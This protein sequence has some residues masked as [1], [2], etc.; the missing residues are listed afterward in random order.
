MNLL[1]PLFRSPTVEAELSEVATL[2][3]MLDFESALARAESRAGIFPSSAAASISAACRAEKF[4]GVT[5]AESAASAGNLAIPLIKQLTNLVAQT[6]SDAARYVHF[7]A[8]SQDAIDTGRILQLRR[9]LAL[10]STDLDQLSD[11]LAQ[12]A[13]KHRSTLITARTWMQHALPT[14]FGAKVAGW[15]DAL[16]RDRIRIRETQSR[17]VVLQ[18]GGAVGTLAALG[19]KGRE[20]AKNLSAE[21]N[22]P[23]THLPW[24]SNRDRMAEMATTLGLCTGTLGKIARDISLHS[25]TE[26]AEL[27]EPAAPGRGGSSTMPHKRN[28]I[29][30]AIVLSAALRVPALVATMLSAMPQEYERGLGGWHAEWE[31]LPEIV[32]LAAGAL[33]HLAAIAAHLEVDTARMR[34]NLGLTHGLIY[35]EAV[36]IA[37]SEKTGRPSAHALLE[38]A[39]TRARAQQKDLREILSNDEKISPHLSAQDLD[40]LFDPNSYLGSAESFVDEVL[41]AHVSNRA[42]ISA[43]RS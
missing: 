21:L 34:Q 2:Q 27:F 33:H 26:I 37:L 23:L 6:D 16:D 5:L 43:G 12:L 39:C 35:A 1:A 42:T 15:L 13:K 41:T 14:T 4:D 8:T 20:V 17:C 11:S 19:A 9:A 30:S 3:S 36:T 29:T 31:T 18:F 10:I 22:L 24:H 25:Q 38:S 28:P 32:S 40:R 7:G